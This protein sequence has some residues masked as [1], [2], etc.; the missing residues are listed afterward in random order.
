[1]KFKKAWTNEVEVCHLPLRRKKNG[2]FNG[3]IIHVFSILESDYVAETRESNAKLIRMKRSSAISPSMDF[4]MSS[5][6]VAK[7]LDDPIRNH[8]VVN[9]I[10][11]IV[12]F[13]V[14][15]LFEIGGN[16]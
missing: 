11:T 13:F 8:D 7:D 4:N 2:F 1:M 14:I 9:A 3:N 16:K 10:Y 12:I 5:S 6:T 15:F